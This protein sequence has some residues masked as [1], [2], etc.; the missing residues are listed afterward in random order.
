[1]KTETKL[2]ELTTQEAGSRNLH[3][4]FL[5]MFVMRQTCSSIICATASVVTPPTLSPP[6]AADSLTALSF[7]FS[8]LERFL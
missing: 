4:I 3:F 8:A 2:R 6:D 7:S 1:M 5:D